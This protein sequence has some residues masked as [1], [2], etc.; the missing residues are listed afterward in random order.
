MSQ[1]NVA[2]SSSGPG[3]VGATSVANNNQVTLVIKKVFF[4]I[5]MACIKAQD[6]FCDVVLFG[7]CLGSRGV[8]LRYYLCIHHPAVIL[9]MDGSLQSC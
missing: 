5:K 4:K 3:K 6:L 7:S 2:K 8:W 1:F 9:V